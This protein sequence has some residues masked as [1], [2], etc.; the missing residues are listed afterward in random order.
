MHFYSWILSP[1]FYSLSSIC[2]FI[3]HHKLELSFTGK[4]DDLIN[5]GLHLLHQITLPLL[6]SRSTELWLWFSSQSRDIRSPVQLTSC[7]FFFQG[8]KKPRKVLVTR[9]F[10]PILPCSGV[11][12]VQPLVS[13]IIIYNLHARSNRNFK[14]EMDV[15]PDPS[16][17]SITQSCKYSSYVSDC[18][19]SY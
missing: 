10:L 17:C 6:A 3:K 11:S 7:N 8:G 15:K 9:Y 19:K 4:Q 18:I 14:D 13:T 16:A 12:Q 5:L 2:G 1:N